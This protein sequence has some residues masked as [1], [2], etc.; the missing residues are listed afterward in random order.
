MKLL[1]IILF[2]PLFSKGQ[3]IPAPQDSVG[4]VQPWLN[5]RGQVIWMN[6]MLMDIRN[7]KFD[8]L[9]YWVEFQLPK[10]MPAFGLNIDGMSAIPTFGLPCYA[11]KSA[12]PQYGQVWEMFLPNN[13][14]VQT[15]LD[16]GFKTTRIVQ[17]GQ[18]IIL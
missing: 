16:R 17:T 13:R 4:Y 11:I 6:T 10:G 1:A 12:S 3:T 9:D 8:T 15:L 18:K 7:V 14:P 5:E 2:I